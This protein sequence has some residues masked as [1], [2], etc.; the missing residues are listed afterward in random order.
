M[1]VKVEGGHGTLKSIVGHD[2]DRQEKSLNSRCSRMAKTV[3]FW[4]WRQSFNNFYFDTLSFFQFVSLFSL[5]YA[6]RL[7]GGGGGPPQPRPNPPL[8]SAPQCRRPTVNSNT[9]GSR[10][11]VRIRECSKYRKWRKNQE[12]W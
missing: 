9:Q 4:P 6:K 8:P 1:V 2:V 10:H 7:G 5:C 11:F 3:T 12:F